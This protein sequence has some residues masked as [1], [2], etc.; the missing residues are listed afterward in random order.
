MVTEYAEV[1]V[2]CLHC[3][4]ALHRIFK[5]KERPWWM[6]QDEVQVLAAGQVVEIR[7]LELEK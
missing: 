6:C 1:W 4:G 2:P 7:Y 3:N 5:G